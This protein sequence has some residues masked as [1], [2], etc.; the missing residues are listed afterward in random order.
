[1][2]GA[3]VT[4]PPYAPLSMAP[5]TDALRGGRGGG[6]WRFGAG[7]A[8]GLSLTSCTVVVGDLEPG[9]PCVDPEDGCRIVSTRPLA[10]SETSPLGV[11]ETM[12]SNVAGQCIAN[13]T[14][15][16]PSASPLTITP[17]SGVDTVRVTVALDRDS[18]RWVDRQ[19]DPKATCVN[20]GCSASLEA[21]A[22]VMLELNVGSIV[23]AQQATITI[24]EHSPQANVTFNVDA[25]AA[26]DWL[27]SAAPEGSITVRG[28]L[29][30]PPTHCAGTLWLQSEGAGTTA[31]PTPFATWSA[32]PRCDTGEFTV[33]LADLPP[34]LPWPTSLA[35]TPRP[36]RIPA[37]W[38]DGSETELQL[39]LLTPETFG[40]ARPLDDA[41]LLVTAPVIA[42][43]STA[44]DRVAPMA[45]HGHAT[46]SLTEGAVRRISL[47]TASR[48]DC[49]LDPLPIPSLDCAE[50]TTLDVQLF[51]QFHLDA[52]GTDTGTLQL[53]ASNRESPAHIE[54]DGLSWPPPPP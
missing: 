37:A 22:E 25:S 10:W 15:N 39:L 41:E 16:L 53:L 51:A 31:V 6:R 46:L 50:W 19:P 3:C 12:L 52:A 40:C 33:A 36:R 47:Q 1:M 54:L 18:A 29:H 44:D 24:T 4:L 20:R 30:P 13:F 35:E 38:T 11:T 7:V 26:G 48:F 17:A 5:G 27:A 2:T 9:P 28:E 34:G 43:V 21:N 45:T 49:A 32:L 8:L 23:R 14:W 42:N